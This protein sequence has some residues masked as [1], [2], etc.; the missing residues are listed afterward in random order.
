M[1][2]KAKTTE[3]EAWRYT[4]QPRDEWPNW[5]RSWV[6]YEGPTAVLSRRS[7]KQWLYPGEWLVRDLD[8]DPE[9]LTHEQMVRE[10]E[11]LLTTSNAREGE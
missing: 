4:G 2:V 5:V 9:W 6:Y 8:G 10:Y 1:I 7:G 11:E 3:R